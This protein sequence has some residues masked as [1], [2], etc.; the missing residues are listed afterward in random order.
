MS[1]FVNDKSPA[2]TESFSTISALEGLILGVNIPMISQVILSSESLVANVACKG[3][4]V[5]VSPLMDQEV[6]GL[7]EVPLTVFADKLL[8]GSR[9]SP[10]RQFPLK[11]VNSSFWDSSRSK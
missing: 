2:L 5:S 6:V 8:L 1:D 10:S 9:R 11:N 7:C 3:P 4:L